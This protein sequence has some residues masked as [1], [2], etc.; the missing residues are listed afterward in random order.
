MA[1]DALK[2][3]LTGTKD[4]RGPKGIMARGKTIYKGGLNSARTGGGANIGRPV[5][6]G[7]GSGG[8]ASSGGGGSQNANVG[9]GPSL[10]EIVQ[11]FQMMQMRPPSI[12][13]SGLNNV[14]GLPAPPNPQIGPPGMG[15]V[16]GAINPQQP[17]PGQFPGL[18]PAAIARR[19]GVK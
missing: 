5:S 3:R 8:S 15:G 11:K 16:G 19:L 17:N 2:R 1:N 10:Q 12:P 4:S 14:S 9:V 18:N 7:M 13:P 6:T